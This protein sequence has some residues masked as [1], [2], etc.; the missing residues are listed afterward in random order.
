MTAG[1]IVVVHGG[2]PATASPDARDRHLLRRIADLAAGNPAGVVLV[3]T[4]PVRGSTVASDVQAAGITLVVAVA[5]LDQWLGDHGRAAAAIVAADVGLAARV[6]RAVPDIP[7]I[8]DLVELPSAVYA[9]TRAQQD[10]L[11]QPGFDAVAARLAGRD[12]AVLAQA[13]L[14]TCGDDDVA[15][16]VRRSCPAATVVVVPAPVPLEPASPSP[17]P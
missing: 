14:V 12:A 2:C 16:E 7:L 4:E 8:V 11:E 15:A 9:R 10:P 17:L 6:H 1:A 13:A 3:V 5:G